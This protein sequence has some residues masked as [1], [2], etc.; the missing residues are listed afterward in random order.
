MKEL[1]EFLKSERI[2][3]GM[4]L[5]EIQEITKIRTRYLKAIED[6]DFSVMPALVYA[7]GFVKSYAEALGLDGNEL[8][9]KYEYLFQEKEE[10][11]PKKI[12]RKKPIDFS[13]FFLALKKMVIAV[14]IIG[15]I[16]YGFYYFFSQVKKGLA[17]LPEQNHNEVS[18]I[19]GE[20][21]T[22]PQ[23]SNAPQLAPKTSVEKVAESAKRIEY[24]IIPAG[25]NYRVEINIPGEKCWFSIKVDGNLAYEG[26]MTKDMFKTFEVKDDISILMGYPPAVKIIVDGEELPILDTPSPVTIDIH[27]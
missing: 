14:L 21:T 3:K 12:Y 4:T 6:G 8:V 27:K 15:I 17:P 10:A 7:K 11:I 9:K 19:P 24:K 18:T 16:G 20:K 25:E 2:K 13:P 22:P 23:E 26:L 5:E 1:G